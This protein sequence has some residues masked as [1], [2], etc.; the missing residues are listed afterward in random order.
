MKPYKSFRLPKKSLFLHEKIIE[1]QNLIFN[2]IIS[3][4]QL[5]LISIYINKVNY[6]SFK[7]F[8][9]M[10]LIQ[11]FVTLSLF[12]QTK[13]IL[14]IKHMVSIWHKVKKTTKVF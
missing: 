14:R 8:I 1:S 11:F 9:Y 5:Y 3:Q 4:L 10:T 2:N 13:N 12:Q 7:S 6:K